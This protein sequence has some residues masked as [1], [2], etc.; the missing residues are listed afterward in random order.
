M[1][2]FSDVDISSLSLEEVKEKLKD[3]GECVEN[4]VNPY[5]ALK[6]TQRCRS[7]VFWHD[8]STILKSGYL[9]VTVHVL[10]DPAV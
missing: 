4:D 2:L 5:E 10:Y 9:L 8:H 3:I 6:N 1:R 7:L